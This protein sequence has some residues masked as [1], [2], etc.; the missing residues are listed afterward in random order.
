MNSL[1]APNK[2]FYDC[3]DFPN[4]YDPRYRLIAMDAS[5]MSLLI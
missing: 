1:D 4:V 2:W 3:K 5:G